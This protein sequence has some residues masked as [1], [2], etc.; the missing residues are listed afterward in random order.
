MVL[1]GNIQ[2]KTV[3]TI[4]EADA[5]KSGSVRCFVDQLEDKVARRVG[6]RFNFRTRI[7]VDWTLPKKL[8][9]RLLVQ[10]DGALVSFRN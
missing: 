10:L 1:K 8:A 5:Y 9:G 4:N 2:I 6:H 3:A 7:L